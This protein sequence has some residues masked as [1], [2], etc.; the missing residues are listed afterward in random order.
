MLVD[1]RFI[2][3]NI[4]RCATTSFKLTCERNNINT[5]YF[6]TSILENKKDIINLSET[7]SLHGHESLSQLYEKFG[8]S[9]P[10][11]AVRRNKYDRLY[12][13]WKEIISTYEEMV[14]LVPNKSYTD[15]L[16]KL[17]TIKCKDIF[18]FDEKEYNLIDAENIHH[19]IKKFAEKNDIEYD[20]N[21][22]NYMRI[23]YLHP[24]WL[25]LDD[26]R[27]I[28]FD[29][30]KLHLL[31]NWVSNILSIDFKLENINTSKHIECELKLDNEFIDYYNEFYSKY[32][33][34]KN[35]KTVI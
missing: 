20:F 9:Y 26:P 28:W 23:F 5:E 17:K 29:F 15:T 34:V 21:I 19:L 35:I 27:I 12:S 7:Q 25:H 10:V 18:F 33:V 13:S 11:I 14:K 30:D 2:Y 3:I 16:N 22:D 32:E 4:P 1:N 6:N 8:Y 24:K 31:E